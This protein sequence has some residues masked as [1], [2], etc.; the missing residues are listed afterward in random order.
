MDSEVDK[1]IEKSLRW[2]EEIERLRAVIA[3]TKLEESLKWGKPCYSFLDKNI[4]IIQPFKNSLGL[5]FF[6]G[7]L[8]KDPN[9]LLID[10]GPNSQA[11]M[12]LEFESTE[13]ISKLKVVIKKYIEEAIFLEE[14]GK[15][16]QFKKSQGPMPAELKKMFA[17][18]P[19]FKKAFENLTPGRQRGYILHF[20]NAKRSTTRQS[21]IEKL[22][23]RI[24]AGKGINEGR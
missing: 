19:K 13:Q 2:H 6:K 9:K 18:N 11:A 24:L 16:V 3:T 5:M 14:S 15:K 17:K 10:N 4:A 20:S 8:L 12:R 21:R 1:F 23:P 7:K 22:L